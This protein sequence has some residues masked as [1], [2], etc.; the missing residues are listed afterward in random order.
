MRKL[1][2]FTGAQSTGKTTLLNKV[3]EL[4]PNR[5][6]YVTEVTRRIQRLG[7][8]INDDAKN[9]DLTQSLIIGDHLIN[10][11][12]VHEQREEN[13]TDI[14]LDRCIV[15]GYI[16]TKYFYEQDKVS[17]TVMDFA[18]YWF[19]ELTPKYD[20]IFY[21]NPSNV[22]L[23]DDGVRSTS[24]GFR[25][26]IIELYNTEF[27]DK[28]DNICTLNGSVEERIEVMKIG[29]LYSQ[30]NNC[31]IMIDLDAS[32]PVRKQNNYSESAGQLCEGCYNKQN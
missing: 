18:E 21:T 16:Y 20:V 7:I 23:V 31:N 25:E 17:R 10:Y 2:T 3:K 24:S 4:Y 11:M 12:K 1:F 13:V 22:K 28:Y 15:D 27:I 26:R 9:Y 32:K 6:E 29:M 8:S 30:C 14:L 5:F 19:K